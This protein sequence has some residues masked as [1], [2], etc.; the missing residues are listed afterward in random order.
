MISLPDLRYV[1]MYIW[2]YGCIYVYEIYV[3]TC[4]EIFLTLQENFVVVYVCMYGC[5]DGCI[6]LSPIYP[7]IH[8]CRWK[9]TNYV[10]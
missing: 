9:A 4:G 8:P 3:C 6:S 5:M 1:C 10:N 7:S 2:M